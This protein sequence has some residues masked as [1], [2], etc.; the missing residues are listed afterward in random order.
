LHSQIAVLEGLLLR[1]Q[2]NCNIRLSPG[3]G[4]QQLFIVCVHDKFFELQVDVLI[5]E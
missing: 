5:L 4:A 1:A 2:L 3:N